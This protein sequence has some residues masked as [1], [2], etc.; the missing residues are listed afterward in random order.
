MGFM[1]SRWGLGA[2]LFLG[3]AAALPAQEPD[4]RSVLAVL[5][6]T[7]SGI[8]AAEGALFSD[9]LT[10]HL[11]GSGAYRI[12]DRSERDAV[13]K[14]IE[15]SL[16]DCGDESCQLEAG[17]LLS[18]SRIVVGSIGAL[19][20][21]FLVSLRLLEVETGE[22]LAGV[23]EKYPSLEALAGDA[24]RL[25]G[26]LSG[27][28]EAAAFR[29]LTA[30]SLISSAKAEELQA[31]M[32]RLR[33]RVRYERYAEWLRRKGF[34]GYERD[35]VIEEKLVFLEEYL[36]QSNSHGH[37]LDLSACFL[38]PHQ[39]AVRNSLGDLGT[40]R[41]RG[42]LGIAAGWSYQFSNIFSVGL[43]ASASIGPASVSIPA[44][45]YNSDYL[46][47]ALGAGPLVALGDRVTGLAVSLGCG[48]G[49]VGGPGQAGPALP[50]RGGLF[51]KGYYLGYTGWPTLAE[52]SFHHQL[53][54]GYS[55]FFGRRKSWPPRA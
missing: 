3:W 51:F 31:R 32:T 23:S 43:W 22:A 28:Q 45:G 12:I 30:N 20:N 17:R 40:Q 10:T 1:T 44:S 11:V 9:V 46:G 47:S 13:L 41:L 55:I 15:F 42:F 18:A 27:G 37:S 26:A 5:D 4:A 52:G 53:E 34:A 21:L 54:A 35:A 7:V 49:N 39:Y 14:E 50:L 48:Y 38:L 29:P 25:A 8:S 2:L 19:G 24:A 33:R 6:F 16:S 36:D